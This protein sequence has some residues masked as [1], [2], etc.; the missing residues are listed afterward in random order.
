MMGTPSLSS[1]SLRLARYI[2][3]S[4]HLPWSCHTS[5]ILPSPLGKVKRGVKGNRTNYY[6]WSVEFGPPPLVLPSVRWSF[7][8]GY[9]QLL[10]N[11]FGQINRI[12]RPHTHHPFIEL[13]YKDFCKNIQT[14]KLNSS[15][16]NSLFLLS[17]EKHIF[18]KFGHFSAILYEKSAK[19]GRG[20]FFGR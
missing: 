12:L 6:I 8:N 14:K 16:L 11:N 17:Y 4:A 2:L 18:L 9:C 19:I 15:V 10:A 7:L 1:P 13:F 3:N 5:P 20:Y